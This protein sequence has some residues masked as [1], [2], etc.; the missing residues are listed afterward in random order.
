MSGILITLEGID[1]TGKSTI[2]SELAAA[3]SS[4]TPDFD[5]ISAAAMPAAEDFVFTA[6]PTDGEIG[7]LLQ[8]R[9]QRQQVPIGNLNDSDHLPDIEAVWG[10]YSDDL[11]L[12]AE[13]L[14]V[15]NMESIQELF[16]FLADHADHLARTVV[17]SIEKGKVVISDRYTDSRVAYQGVTLRSIIS[18][19]LQW[20]REL[21]R[22]WSIVPD[23]TLL[24]TI[25]PVL[26][27]KRC[28]SR[29]DLVEDLGESG[30][31]QGGTAKFE[32]EEFLREVQ[33]NFE[34]L[35]ELEP[36]RFTLIDASCPVEEVVEEALS[37]IIDFLNFRR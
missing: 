26:A 34:Q 30:N 9:H 31:L 28:R 25:D 23:L 1:G 6:E 3:L 18:D 16:L 13:M 17:P 8:R 32:R 27:V 36:E 4:G 2:A 12:D 10:H 14:N 37:A 5:K 19:P 29:Y 7:R 24:F 11:P 33:S 15:L 21:H 22:P 20:I 35:A